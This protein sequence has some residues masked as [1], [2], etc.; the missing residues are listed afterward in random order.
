LRVLG[1]AP[2]KKLDVSRISEY[3]EEKVELLVREKRGR[4]ERG[5]Y[6]K[7]LSNLRTV[8]KPS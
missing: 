8:G 6:T 2:G 7:V 5:G 4:E 3:G 1:L